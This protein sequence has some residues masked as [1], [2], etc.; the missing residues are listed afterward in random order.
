MRVLRVVFTCVVLL[1]VIGITLPLRA[2]AVS[3]EP[4]RLRIGYFAFDPTTVDTFIDDT[5]VPLGLSWANK[6]WMSNVC[7]GGLQRPC[8]AATPFMSFPSGLHRFAFTPRGQGLEAAI[9]GPKEFLLE[10]GH[11]YSMPIIG[12]LKDNNLTRLFIDETTAFASADPKADFMVTLVNDYRGAPGIDIYLGQTLVRANLPYGEFTT[13]TNRDPTA[14]F[15]ATAAGDR[16]AVVQMSVAASEPG[17]SDLS[18]IMGGH[19]GE[20]TVEAWNWDYAG[21]ITT[22]DSGTVTVGTTVDGEIAQPGGRVRYTLALDSSARLN[23]YAKVAGPRYTLDP[24]LYIYDAGGLP[25]FWND[26]LSYS[27]TMDTGADAGMEGIT[28]KAGRYMLEVGGDYAGYGMTGN[29][30]L[31]VEAARSG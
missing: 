10:P 6:T 20:R 17:V 30:T 12:D 1:L 22:V 27:G 23:I 19:P 9:L 2:Q 8:L 25:W 24:S 14:M 4:A 21:L 5:L 29:Y 16:T 18:A 7:G 11:A 3:F 15:I 31:T 26:E 28:L 13:F